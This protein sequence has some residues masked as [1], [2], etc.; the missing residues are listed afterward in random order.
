MFLAVDELRWMGRNQMTEEAAD[1][2]PPRKY[3][4]V[5]D[6]EYTPPK[7]QRSL[8]TGLTTPRV[9]LEGI[10]KLIG[11]GN[12]RKTAYEAYGINKQTFYRWIHEGEEAREK[13]MQ[14]EKLD[15]TS[16]ECLWF[17]NELEKASGKS[18]AALVTRWYTEAVDGDWRAAERFLAKAFPQR[19]SD[20]ATRLEVTGA[21]GGP[22][23]QITATV[24]VDAE[25]DAL[26]QRKVLEA[27]VD[28]GDLP[29]EVLA[30]IDGED[31]G[32]EDEGSII[33]ADIVQE[34]VQPDSPA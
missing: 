25:S 27:L 32:S 11:A 10:I 28:A 15:G 6:P 1:E 13:L 23:T 16:E 8:R 19:W 2:T 30:A 9:K 4:R 26:R 3:K 17:L 24:H 33:E 20:P 31:N 14:G 7:I 18:E 21:N 22:M 29:M 5:L 12:Y 34:A